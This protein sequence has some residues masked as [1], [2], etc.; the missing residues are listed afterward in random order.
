MHFL[1]IF[2][3]SGCGSGAYKWRACFL[4]FVS[5]F[6]YKKQ[7]KIA[8]NLQAHSLKRVKRDRSQIRRKMCVERYILGISLTHKAKLKKMLVGYLV[9][10]SIKSRRH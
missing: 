7:E 6:Y 3:I 9:K 4:A 1:L 5:G 8:L 10:T 2:L